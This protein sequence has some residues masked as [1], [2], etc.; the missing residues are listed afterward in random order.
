V[1]TILLVEDE[2]PVRK[3]AVSILEAKG[4]TVLQAAN[5]VAAFQEQ[6]RFKGTIHLLLTDVVMPGMSGPELAKKLLA[7]RRGIRVL[8]ITGYADMALPVED[9]P[10]PGRALLHK[11][12]TPALLATKVRELLDES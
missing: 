7:L 9:G 4:Y 5:A 8:F 2:E 12:F 6:E 11:P 1:E 10:G 3:L